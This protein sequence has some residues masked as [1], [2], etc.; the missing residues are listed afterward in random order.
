MAM[1]RLQPIIDR[2]QAWASANNVTF[3]LF[4]DKTDGFVEQLDQRQ[5]SEDYRILHGLLTGDIWADHDEKDQVSHDGM[6]LGALHFSMEIELAARARQTEE[7]Q[8]ER[9]QDAQAGLSLIA[10]AEAGLSIAGQ[11]GQLSLKPNG[12]PDTRDN[13]IALAKAALASLSRQHH[14][15]SGAVSLPD[16]GGDIMNAIHGIEDKS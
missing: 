9:S 6:L 7:G 16:L 11:D 8:Q 15:I 14:T 1:N 5:L 3:T 13:R 2:W 12:L 10:Q 4:M